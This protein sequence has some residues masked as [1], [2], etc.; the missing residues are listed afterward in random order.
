MHIQRKGLL[1]CLLKNISC[2]P[3]GNVLVVEVSLK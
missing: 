1:V 3:V 2:I